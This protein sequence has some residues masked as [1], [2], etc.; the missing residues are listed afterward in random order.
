MVSTLCPNWQVDHDPVRVLAHDLAAG[1]MP[2][3]SGA[4]TS[5]IS[6]PAGEF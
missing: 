1:N 6:L 2:Q 4:L 5:A 3:Q